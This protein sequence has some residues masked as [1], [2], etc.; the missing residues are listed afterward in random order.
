MS[1]VD[2]FE[3]R[4]SAGGVVYRLYSDRCEFLLCGRSS[5]STWNLPKGTPDQGEI[6]EDTA[7][8]EVQEETGIIPRIES[9][10]GSI[11]YS[12]RS[13]D[14]STEYRKVVHFYLMAPVGGNIVQHDSEFDCVKWFVDLDALKFVTF[15]N[16]AAILRRA[17]QQ[18]GLLGSRDG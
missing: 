15:E 16:E 6:I 9:S 18:L 17:M 13:G 2:K 3:D 14:G 11:N 10:L 1:H 12:F 7:V 4:V 8:R 5:V